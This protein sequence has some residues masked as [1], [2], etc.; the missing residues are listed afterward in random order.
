MPLKH[1]F[2]ARA[3]F[4]VCWSQ[5]VAAATL[6]T[7]N[8]VFANPL[9]NAEIYEFLGADYS[10]DV[11]STSGTLDLR[12]VVTA[13]AFTGG[14]S[15][16]NGTASLS[17][18]A[19]VA[20]KAEITTTLNDRRIMPGSHLS[21]ILGGTLTSLVGLSVVIWLQAMRGIRAR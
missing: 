21:L 4:V 19:R 3:P 9:A 18:T 2:L 12:N 5:Q 16:L 11:L 8:G 6:A 14:V 10:Y 7:T 13:T 17:A 1:G 15:L 20:R